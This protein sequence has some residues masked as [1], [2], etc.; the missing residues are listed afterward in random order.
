[1]L[2][3][4]PDNLIPTDGF[5]RFGEKLMLGKN[6]LLSTLLFCTIS[7]GF[8][9]DF[10][11]IKRTQ[12]NDN[13]EIYEIVLKDF[14]VSKS[15]DLT[16]S[17]QTISFKNG[18]SLPSSS[19]YDL[20]FRLLNFAVPQNGSLNVQLISKSDR[21]INNVFL[22][23]KK[24][25]QIAETNIDD[26]ITIG[27]KRRFRDM[28]IQDI[29]INPLAYNRTTKS[30]KLT[31]KIKLKVTYSG[32]I[33]SSALYKSRGKLDNLYKKL[34]VNFETGKNWQIPKERKIFK[35]KSLSTGTFYGFE[36]TQ[37][38]LYK[39]TASTLSNNGVNI[40]GLNINALEL[41]NNGGHTLSLATHLEQWNPAFTQEI[42]IHVI[43]Q[44]N[45]GIFDGNDYFLFY[46][47][48]VNSWFY[49]SDLK[50]FSHQTH[51]YDTKNIYY[52]SASGSNGKRMV[53]EDLPA[54]SGAIEQNYFLERFHF[55]EEKVNLLNSGPDWYGTRFFGQSGNHSIDFELEA[56]VNSEI[57]PSITMRFKGANNIFWPYN[58]TIYRYY[59]D[60]FLNSST[61]HSA[62]SL[63][64]KSTFTKV[65][66][67][68]SSSILK[69]G[70]NTLQFSYSSDFD[71]SNVY[72]DY[73]N[74]TYP[75]KL[76]T[77][78]N[79]ISF[80]HDADGSNKR[81]SV[82][83][84]STVNDIYL[85][86][87]TNPLHVKILAKDQQSIS[88][89]YSFDIPAEWDNK[90]FI[91]SSL[92]SSSITT[93]N[94]LSPYTTNNNLLDQSK[95][96]DYIIIT[97][98]SLLDYGQQI[99]ELH[100]NL[101]TEVVSV[102]DIFFYFNNGVQDPTAIRNF[103]RYAYYNWE[104]PNISY[105]LLLGD[106]H[107]DYRN[108]SIQDSSVVPTFQI[109]GLDEL[110]SRESD[111][112]YVDL[113][114]RINSIAPN[115]I[116]PSLAIGRLPVENALDAERVVEKLQIYNQN[117]VRNG[118]QT[119]ITIVGDDEKVSASSNSTEWQHQYQ[120]EELATMSQLNR[121]NISRIYLSAFE[122]VA[123]G[124]AR[125][126]PDAT[127]ALLDQ[128][129]R[130]TLIVNYTGHGSPTQ[131]AHETLFSFDRDY[132]KINNEGAFPFFI[133]ATC[134]FG[135]FDNPNHISFTEALIW[136]EKSGT[137]GSLAATRLVYSGQNF[138]FNKS[139]YRNLF[140]DGKP[141]VPLG[142]AFLHSFLS[143]TAGNTNDQKYHLFADPAMTLADA[144]QD[145]EITSITPDT[146]QALSQV[147]VKAN[148]M[149][150]DSPATNFNGGAVMLVNDATFE[151][152]ETGGG[153]EYNLTGPL[154]FRGEVSVEDGDM[155]ANFIVPKSIRY[156]DKN[157]GRITLYAWD[158][159]TNT[160]ASVIRKNL[161]LLGSSNLAKETDG[162]EIDIFFDGQENFSSGD[163]I[164]AN[165][166]LI[167]ELSDDSGI[168]LTGQLGHKIE[169]KIDETTTINISES[170]TYERD[171]FTKGM[172][173]YPITSLEP[174][175]HTL[176]LQAFD[177]L[178]NR[179][180]QTVE[181]K[182]TSASGLV[183][184]DVVNYPNPF[185]RK[186]SFTF[187]TNAVG[188]EATIKIYTLSGRLIEKLEGNFTEAGYNEIE[189]SG[190]D[191]DGNT[192][193]NGVY[194][195]KLVLKEGKDKKEKIEKMVVIK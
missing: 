74:I 45:N 87:V 7:L 182:I 38:G 17:Y 34:L 47:K 52:L 105:I 73:F 155:E 125:L 10:D 23:E 118:W 191:R 72:L 68:E 102:E 2:K 110:S 61:V 164:S 9:S 195:Y 183:L 100:S 184:E 65:K 26:L 114:T 19:I 132:S 13:E 108:I 56:D 122:T 60:I 162:P 107:F 8:A 178:N 163:I 142:E 70:K 136:K 144:H 16:D 185:K 3:S 159:A 25:Y 1:M 170:F 165:P 92:S 192:L 115:T 63:A 129:N 188:A 39:I 79:S 48:A 69:S 46:G 176:T 113:D 33:N 177:N 194:L 89:K 120:A 179:T 119:N 12:K 6:I 131:W 75:K 149:I 109:Y 32:N 111:I 21:T 50:K 101:K 124:R 117:Q 66:E 166:V 94:S 64:N 71:E 67:L 77:T 54:I 152:V 15:N 51:R 18:S 37:D 86:D 157:S 58:S 93:I 43:D 145:I 158:D 160:S 78:S 55:E 123:G 27:E 95:S 140:P 35:T 151:D 153:L 49:D 5:F 147:N 193:A 97:R 172:V 4:I 36:I 83:G 28:M 168:N 167:A 150:D 11:D 134:D 91:V 135:L 174:G 29:I 80:F 146:L 44:N 141:S 154:V 181:F 104:T 130:G 116:T 126:K 180:E 171:S 62:L 41:Y 190:L 175:D 161:L 30:L 143:N 85:F 98:K 173:R 57:K 96:A 40:D 128:I 121:F 14:E 76:N 137:I 31:H 127:Q 103:I 53:I 169:L 24:P 138:A 90:N 112:F 187:Q 82:S 59:F 156:K 20:P 148:V 139:F 22:E 81:Y 186:T 42:P 88:G 99:A 84:L 106:G 133:A 189:W